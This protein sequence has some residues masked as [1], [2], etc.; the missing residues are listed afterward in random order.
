MSRRWRVGLAAI[1]AAAALTTPWAWGAVSA[2]GSGAAQESAVPPDARRGAEQ[3]LLT[4]PEWYLVH[5]PAEYARIVAVKPPQAFPFIGQVGQL[6]SAYATVT[7]EQ[8]RRDYPFNAGYHVMIWVI[9][10][11]TTAE[12]ALRSVYENT[13]GRVSWLL[14]GAR[15]TDED[16]YAAKAAQ[17][18]VDFI[19]QEP[20]YLFDF[21]SRLKH[22]WTDVPMTGPGMV[23]KWERR[24][25]LTTEYAIKA[26][27]GK[28]IEKATRAAYT[29]A[30]MTT[31][32]VVEQ[33]PQ[34]WAPPPRV[35]VLRRL[36]DG[37]ALLS[38]PRYFDFRLAA[39]T[40]AQQGVRIVDI[41][42]NGDKSPILVTV[43]ANDDA[44]PQKG[45]WQVLF[46]QPLT[47][48][49]HARRLG[50]LM[51][52]GRLSTFLADAPTM[53]FTPEHVYDY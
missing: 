7:R 26:V 16:R 18:Y 50:L 51:P 19:R 49:A 23:R 31:D 14:D 43:W 5:S 32:V 9:A 46:E 41:A 53:G 52:V 6:W 1:A 3:T 22:L 2:L 48:P 27:Y 12:Y 33:L 47:M 24:Y 40:L 4:F 10:T 8:M 15:L 30:L 45:D 25:A 44:N 13:L 11:S 37:R 21:T 35:E 20:W 36:P 28:L 42:G 17:E 39:T 34:T 29:P 38:L